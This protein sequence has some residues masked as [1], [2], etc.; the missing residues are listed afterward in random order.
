MSQSK[1]P[2]ALRLIA[3][4][5]PLALL[6]AACANGDSEALDE[7][8]E[9]AGVGA[10]SEAPDATEA[11]APDEPVAAG[12]PVAGGVLRYGIEDDADGI[13][14]TATALAASG[15]VMAEAVFDPL[16]AWAEDGTAVPY[17]A[18][19]FTPND[20]ATSWVVKLRPGIKF[21][22]G[23]DLTIDAIISNFETQYADPLVGLT[24][25]PFYPEE[26]AIERID[27]L[28]ARFNLLESNQYWPTVLTGQLGYVSSPT[29]IAA[30]LEDPTL[31][32]QPVGT[33]PFKF[34]LREEDSVTRFVR[35]DDYWGGPV[36]LD[37]VEFVPVPDPDTRSDLLLQGELDALQT[38]DQ[39][40]VD[41]L[42][43]SAGITSIL[44]DS[45]DEE[46]A[47]M[48]SAVPPFDDIRA[49]RAL[50]L[51]TPQDNYE[52]LIGLGLSRRANSLF[53]PGSPYFNPDVVQEGDDPE[54]AVALAVE[55]CAEKGTEIN[56]T[57]EGPTCTD[58]KINIE[59]QYSGPS[60][61]GTRIAEILDEGWS[62]A[63]NVSFQELPL[64]QHILDTAFGLYNVSTWGQFGEPDPSMDNVWLM[65]RT[66]GEVSLNWPKFCDEE[67]DELLLSAQA[68]TDPAE[69]V[70]LY[71]ELSQML[72][73]DYIY[74]FFNHA[75][76]N[77]AFRDSVKGVCDRVS[78]DGIPLRC[79]VIGRTF[80]NSVWLDQ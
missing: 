57:I 21:H 3:L 28:T 8:G 70:A 14:P 61:V 29:W 74:I 23:T 55:Y 26:G 60:V 69:R 59:L 1:H 65:C 39:A 19:S 17:L 75:I 25:R 53:A 52:A 41:L 4:A 79:S 24:V 71:Q 31:D 6:A 76:W 45:G 49:R 32:Q 35:N 67:R 78:P 13:N 9:D 18:E 38:L 72:R 80:F 54:G 63:F 51:A 47:M 46:F 68:T 15:L 50:T 66:V 11:P 40:N 56:T 27:D 37:A 5:I 30:A 22:D 62:V 44:D 42:T 16:A 34:D 48:N 33:G 77:N 36:Y 20:D 58:G 7:P 12:E 64:D 2:Y 43:N 73:D 10:E